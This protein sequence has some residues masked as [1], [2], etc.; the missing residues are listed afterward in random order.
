MSVLVELTRIEGTQH[1]K[2]IAAQLLDVA[3]RVQAVRNVCVARMALLIENSHLF[4]GSMQRATISEVLS[5]AAWICGEF[6][7]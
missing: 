2:L 7:S 5:A 1:G 6:P 3:V 4:L